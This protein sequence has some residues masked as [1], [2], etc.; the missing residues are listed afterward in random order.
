MINGFSQPDGI[1][2]GDVNDEMAE[3]LWIS[4]V[5]II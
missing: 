5:H 4:Q 3:N 2:Y 1:A